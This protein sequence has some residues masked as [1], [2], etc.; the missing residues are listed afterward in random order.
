[1]PDMD[2]LASGLF[3]WGGHAA[4][5]QSCTWNTWGEKR[6]IKTSQMFQ[7]NHLFFNV[8]MN[9]AQHLL[10]LWPA[11]L[12]VGGFSPGIHLRESAKLGTN[13]RRVSYAEPS[14]D[15]GL[16]GNSTTGIPITT[17]PLYVLKLDVF[18]AKNKSSLRVLVQTH[19]QSSNFIVD[20]SPLIPCSPPEPLCPH[21]D[22]HH[23]LSTQGFGDRHVILLSP[24]TVTNRR[25]LVLSRLPG[26]SGDRKDE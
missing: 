2:L 21:A 13:T 4:I 1:M 25:V 20:C 16:I 9:N 7:L 18:E 11:C 19:L 22:L 17:C 5:S 6:E 26:R 3:G 23:M 15:F 24:G 12:C 10:N 14:V 8:V